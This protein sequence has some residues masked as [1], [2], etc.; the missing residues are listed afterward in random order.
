MNLTYLKL[1]NTTVMSYDIDEGYYKIYH[2]NLLPFIIRGAVQDTT[3][4][5]DNT[6][7]IAKIQAENTPDTSYPYLQEVVNRVKVTAG[8]LLRLQKKNK[9]VKRK[10]ENQCMYF[11]LFSH[12]NVLLFFVRAFCDKRRYFSG[13]VCIPHEAA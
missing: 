1:Q 5:S 11:F 2:E 9:A 6:K 3:L 8:N 7:S 13:T 12:D 4:I 10:G